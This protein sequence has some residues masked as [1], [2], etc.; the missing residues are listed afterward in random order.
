MRYFFLIMGFV[1]VALATKVKADTLVGAPCVTPDGYYRSYT[2]GFTFFA[3]NSTPPYVT[4]C[5]VNQYIGYEYYSVPFN[6][7]YKEYRRKVIF[8]VIPDCP[9]G[10][11]FNVTSGECEQSSPSCPPN[12]VY[13]TQNEGCECMPPYLTEWD[14]D[15]MYCVMPDCPPFFESHTP[16]LPLFNQVTNVNDCNYFPMA[17]FAYTTLGD[18]VCCY[19]QKNIEDN[20]PLSCGTNEIMVNGSCVPIE[21]GDENDPMA[22]ERECA[23]GSTYSE[24]AGQCVP[25][26]PDTD[27]NED[28]NPNSADADG[29]GTITNDELFQNDEWDDYSGDGSEFGINIG[30][31]ADKVG[32]AIDSYVLLDIPVSVSG[33][34]NAEL[35]YTFTVPIINK[36]HTIE[37]NTYMEKMNEYNPVIKGIVLFLFS[38]SGV[39]LVMAG[40]D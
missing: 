20:D 14:V 24:S 4:D 15:T 21:G 25:V 38:V 26:V 23:E 18:V 7:T 3:Y 31:M 35:S 5:T 12:A 9:S 6:T 19:G 2:G 39:L 22:E 37:A 34:C 8:S 36:T 32:E 16:P 11:D 33:T 10:E 27:V 40:R 17:D 30:G 28:G 1:I 13:N 29:D